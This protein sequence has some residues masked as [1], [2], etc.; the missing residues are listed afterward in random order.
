MAQTSPWHIARAVCPSEFSEFIPQQKTLPSATTAHATGQST[1]M[2]VTFLRPETG[3]GV[4]PC[5]R[6]A[7]RMRSFL[8][9]RWR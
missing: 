3:T 4:S 7:R 9:R 1:E 5:D 6:K 2:P 8:Q